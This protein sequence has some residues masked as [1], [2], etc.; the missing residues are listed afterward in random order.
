MDIAAMTGLELMQAARDGGITVGIAELFGMRMDEVEEGRIAFSLDTG[1]QFA[2]PLGT[3]HGGVAATMLDSVLGC[4]V[5]TT[6]PAGVGYTSLDLNVRYIRSGKL[7]GS[8]IRAEG[9]TVHVG[10]TTATAEGEL[11]DAT[12]RLLATATTTCLI[13][14]PPA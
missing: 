6:L 7:D 9:R 4:A 13:M 2:N 5:H 12:G 8:P 14:R 3:L 10:R 1:P 11:T